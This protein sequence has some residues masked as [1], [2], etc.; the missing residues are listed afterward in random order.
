[1]SGQQQYR[2]RHELLDKRVSV[3][4]VGVGGSGSHVAA[5]LAVLHQSMLALGHPHGLEVSLFDSDTVSAANVGR[6]RFFPQDVGLS[7]A[8]VLANRINLTYGLDFDAVCEDVTPDTRLDSDIVVGCVDTRQ[9]RRAIHQLL[10]NS[11]V[12]RWRSTIWLDLGNGAVDGQVVFGAT[13]R[14]HVEVPAITDLYPEI[15]NPAL[16]PV[17]DGPSCSM[18]EALQKQG[19][20]V[21][22]T[23]ALHATTMLSNLFRTGSLNYNAVFFNLETGRSV[24]LPCDLAHWKR[25]GYKPA[26]GDVGWE[27]EA[28]DNEPALMDAVSA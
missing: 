26:E 13:H 11:N 21:N 6:A 15:M 20:F 28:V 17:D 7:K 23:A 27:P 1:M 14:G 12:G 24:P 19:A 25:M 18:A 10:R 9:S 2:L 8:V 22:A 3:A 5:N 4:V 16:D